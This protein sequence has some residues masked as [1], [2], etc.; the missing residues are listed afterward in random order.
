[1]VEVLAAQRDRLRERANRLE[2]G[3][4][5]ISE[6]SAPQACPCVTEALCPRPVQFR[7]SA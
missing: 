1:M 6:T 2:E 4:F 5:V 3:A 7:F